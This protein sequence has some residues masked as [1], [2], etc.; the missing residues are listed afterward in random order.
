MGIIMASQASSIRLQKVIAQSGLTSRRKA[1]AL[2]VAGRVTVNG[3]V[4]TE[5]GIRI[6]PT[7]D[8]V[9]VD[10]RH[11]KPPQPDTFLMLNK[12]AGYLSTMSDPLDRPTIADLIVTR[13]V[14]IFPVGRLDYDSEGLLLLTNNGAIA[15]ACLH[16]RYHVAKTYEVKIKGILTDEEIAQ[17]EKGVVLDD[18]PTEPARVRKLHKAEANS[19]I[20]M[21]I[22]EGRKHQVKRM[23]EAIGHPV[24]KLRRTKFGPLSLGTL[25]VGHSRYL[26][27]AEANALRALL[28][29]QP[30]GSSGHPKPVSRRAP[31]LSKSVTPLPSA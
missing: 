21:T 16:P 24:I 1:E 26:T 13:G 6:D 12:P 7:R 5:L 4:V 15:H 28:R 8:H 2:I 29:H 20:E 11:I 30:V 3:R 10:G 22:Y 14:R 23:L 9:K 18:G 19:W 31:V 25:P 17:L 27:D